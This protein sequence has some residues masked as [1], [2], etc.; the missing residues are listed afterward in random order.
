MF[1]KKWDKIRLNIGFILMFV[2][3]TFLFF[4]IMYLTQFLVMAIWGY[5]LYN[6]IGGW[7][8]L[9]TSI[10]GVLIYFIVPV[11]QTGKET[12]K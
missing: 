12:K 11:F 3:A 10:F 2:I 4:K 1:M 8:I 7:S 9:G 5:D 6:H